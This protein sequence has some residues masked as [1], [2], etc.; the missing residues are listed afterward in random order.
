MT[1]KIILTSVIF[2][3]VILSLTKPSNAD[4]VK[5]LAAQGINRPIQSTI[6]FMQ[7]SITTTE[8]ATLANAIYKAYLSTGIDWKVLT[9]ITFQESSFK[10]F[11]GDKVC[12]YTAARYKECVYR[13][14][15]PMHVYVDYWDTTFKF[16]EEG[17][18]LLND[19]TVGIMY[20]AWILRI[21]HDKYAKDDPFWIGRYN[22]NT[23]RH[24]LD[25]FYKVMAHVARIENQLAVWKKRK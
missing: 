5:A 10:Y 16:P 14:F 1:H 22:S 4:T 13:S 23:E 25:Y 12:G 8:A 15:G 6:Q 18:E 3:I 20:G 24:K 21:R 7:P 9:A 17:L 2:F 11:R 19:P